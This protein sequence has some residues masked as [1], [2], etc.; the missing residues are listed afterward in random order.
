MGNVWSV[1][2]WAGVHDRTSQTHGWAGRARKSTEENPEKKL[3]PE[4]T[5]DAK[6][7][8]HIFLCLVC[9]PWAGPTPSWRWV[10]AL[11]QGRGPCVHREGMSVSHPC[12]EGLS[13]GGVQEADSV[14]AIPCLSRNRLEATFPSGPK[15]QWSRWSCDLVV[16]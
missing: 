9:L 5:N 12:T 4:H 3:P 14:E 2:W 15:G 13:L 16:G 1:H 6:S 7:A 8:V 11:S 10:G